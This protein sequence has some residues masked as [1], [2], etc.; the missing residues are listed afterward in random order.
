[1]QV[2]NASREF[3]LFFFVVILLVSIQSS[4][5]S[6]R[7]LFVLLNEDSTDEVEY[8][9]GAE[10][11]YYAAWIKINP[12]W[13]MYLQ[14]P[15]TNDSSYKQKRIVITETELANLQNLMNEKE[16]WQFAKKNPQWLG[17]CQTCNWGPYQ[18]IF[19]IIKNPEGQDYIAFKL[20]N[21]LIDVD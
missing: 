17:T 11:S 2:K 6:K 19:L 18:E 7:Q 9:L 12:G 10:G 20:A 13:D 15:T 5:Q 16:F 21:I 3:S 14:E 1:M 8:R 4:C